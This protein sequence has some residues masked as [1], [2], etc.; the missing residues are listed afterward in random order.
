MS[1]KNNCPRYAAR[2]ALYLR[3]TTALR[4]QQQARGIQKR[5]VFVRLVFVS[6]ANSGPT[7]AT[8]SLRA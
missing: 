8:V 3:V 5:L 4:W 1:F 2:R 7:L 6:P